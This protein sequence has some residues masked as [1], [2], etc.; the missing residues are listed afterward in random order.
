MGDGA[1]LDPVF[2]ERLGA[3]VT[4]ELSVRYVAPTPVERPLL[5]RGRAGRA[6]PRF[7]E[8]QGTLAA[9]EFRA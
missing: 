6:A 9:R 2:A 5:G 8:L 7:L 1:P 4:G 3:H